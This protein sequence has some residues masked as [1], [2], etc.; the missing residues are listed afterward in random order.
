MVHEHERP[1]PYVYVS[2]AAS[3]LVGG[4]H[5][6][7][8]Q[9]PLSGASELSWVVP[10][11][12]VLVWIYDDAR[13]FRLGVTHDWGLFLWFAWPVLLPWYVFKTRGRAGWRLLMLLIG[14]ILAPVLGGII[15]FLLRL[16]FRLLG[17]LLRA[18]P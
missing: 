2:A 5:A 15:A 12:A 9:H 8:G 6:I 3:A 14:F 13:R 11:A 16:E 18:L 7:S 17:H 10:L 4:A 1:A